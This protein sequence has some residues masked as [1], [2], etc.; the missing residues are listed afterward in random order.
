M[1]R[2]EYK[3]EINDKE[4]SKQKLINAVGEVLKTKGYIG[5]SAT[6]IAEAAGLSRRLITI[7]FDSVDDLVETYVRNKDYW[8]T[9]FRKVEE[10]TNEN[11]GVGGKKMI[12]YILQNQLDYFYNNPEMQK[13]ILWEISEKTK[14]MYDVS[15]ERERLGSQVFNLVDKEFEGIDIRAISAILVAGIYY[16]VLHAKSTDTLFC[17]IDINQPEGMKRIKNAISLIVEN[18]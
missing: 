6:N 7:Y 10:M 1:A 13:L 14:V 5:L 17:E 4:R 16:M 9:A 3:G 2:K 15:E 18:T 8:T 12:D 11:K